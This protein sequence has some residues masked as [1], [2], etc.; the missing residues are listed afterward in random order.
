MREAIVEAVLAGLPEGAVLGVY[1]GGSSL[2]QWDTVIDYVPEFSDVDIHL[3]LSDPDLLEADLERAFAV[4]ADYEA[5]FA[6]KVPEPLHYPRPQVVV[7]NRLVEDPAFMGPPP[8]TTKTLYGRPH[9]EVRPQPT[10]FDFVR[11]VDRGRLLEPREQEWATN[12]P[13]HVL[14]RPSRYLWQPVRDASWRVSPTGPRVLSV[15]GASF[16]DAWGHNRTGVHRLL[17]DAGQAE[18]AGH[19][20]GYYREA[21]RFFLSGYRDADAARAA[22][23]HAKQVL[24]LGAAAGRQSDC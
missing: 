24:E 23:L 9:E 16:E 11:K 20:A 7:I 8:G 1:A 18:F 4:Q 6:L 22:I 2:K 21:W 14:D 17:V 5:R 19:Y 10:D 15:L 13:A 12:L 3:L